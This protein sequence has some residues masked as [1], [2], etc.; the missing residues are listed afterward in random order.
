MPKEGK[1]SFPDKAFRYL[2]LSLAPSV[3]ASPQAER[4]PGKWRASPGSNRFSVSLGKK[5]RGNGCG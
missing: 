3:P 2:L 5:E 4:G 1:T